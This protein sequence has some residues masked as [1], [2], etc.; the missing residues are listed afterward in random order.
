MTERRSFYRKVGYLVAIAVLWIPISLLSQPASV[1][2]FGNRSPGGK[3][4]RERD[5]Y[6]LS[7][8]ALG[9]IDP[10]SETMKL[11]TLGMRGVA[12]QL[13]WN[14]LHHYQMV[15]D[16]SSVSAVVNQIIRL[17]PNFF[18]VWDFEA[19]NQSYNISVEFDD[20]RDR[21]YWV[22]K[23]IEFLKDGYQYNAT[24][25]RFLARIGWI[26]GN[27]IGKADEHVQ[28]R[29]LFTKQQQEKGERL[30]DNWLVSND[31]YK[32][33]QALV[34][35]GRRLRVYVRGES[36]DRR[37]KDK[38]GQ[39]APS[40]LLFHSEAAMALINYA[41]TIEEEGVFGNQAKGAWENAAHEWQ[42]YADRELPTPYGYTVRLNQLE[43]YKAKI[44]DC[45]ARLEKLLP[46]QHESIRQAKIAKLTTD[47]RSAFDK[48]PAERTGEEA[49]TANVAESKVNVSW[50]EVALRAPA[51]LRPEARLLAEELVT[52]AQM[53]GTIDTYRD[54]V[55]YNYWLTRCQAEPTEDCLEARRLLN[56]A[57]T[58]YDSGEL[59]EARKAYEESFAKWR[60]VLDKFPILRNNNIMADELVDEIDKYKKA[61]GK[62]PGE[63][64]P[65][66]FI[67]QDMVDLNEGKRTVP[68]GEEANPAPEKSDKKPE[69]PADSTK[70]DV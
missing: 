35:S 45:E 43:E 18:S 61:I 37:E 49:N 19:H 17:Q 67:L 9:K 38:P 63:K 16:W 68:R 30:T 48:K 59:F 52:D 54:I 26:Y 21:F 41:D 53:A 1:D 57:S 55:N 15:E 70:K 62:I 60:K 27:K 69:Q 42:L 14:S 32:Q 20:Y 13:L 10:A 34:D 23:G 47:E 65:D 8:A 7:Q 56:K 51:D 31:W 50:D 11:A 39:K 58:S 25:P 44:K 5:E 2:A 40:P 6:H 4:A 33:A 28:Y 29:R 3:L 36:L 22:M 64:F 46:G 24:D 12:V 66:N